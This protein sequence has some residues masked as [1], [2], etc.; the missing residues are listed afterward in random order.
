MNLT[1]GELRSEPTPL[2]IYMQIFA[3]ED[4][5]SFAIQISQNQSPSTYHQLIK[6][7]NDFVRGGLL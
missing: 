1:P 6:K 5:H 2:L 3:Q 7:L 4:P